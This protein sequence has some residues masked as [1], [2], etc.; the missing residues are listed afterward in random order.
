MAKLITAASC[1]NCGCQL[2]LDC[3]DH[4]VDGKLYLT[5]ECEQKCGAPVL[6]YPAPLADFKHLY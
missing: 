3:S 6:T 5:L 4:L 2:K 1:Q